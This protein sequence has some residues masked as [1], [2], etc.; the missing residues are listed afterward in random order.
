MSL[1]INFSIDKWTESMLSITS[2]QKCDNLITC[3]YQGDTLYFIFALKQRFVGT[4]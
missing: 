4:R 2:C 3:G 1:V